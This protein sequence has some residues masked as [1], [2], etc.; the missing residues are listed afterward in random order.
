MING[1]LNSVVAT[2]KKGVPGV[3][4]HAL[5]AIQDENTRL[6]L[7]SIVDGWHVRNGATGS[8][9]G[10]FVTRAEIN[11][12]VTT[13]TRQAVSQ[14]GSLSLSPGEISRA[15]SDLHTQVFESQLFKVLESRIDLIDSPDG[16]IDQFNNLRDG[17]TDITILDEEGNKVT[18]IK[19][20]RESTDNNTAL[21]GQIN[22][23][24]STSTSAAAK[25]LFTVSST[26]YDEKTGLGVVNDRLDDKKTGLVAS[27]A[28]VTEEVETRVN[29]DNALATAINT[30]WATVGDTTALISRKDE[31]LANRTAAKATSWEQV[32][33]AIKDDAGNVIYSSTIK[34]TA[35][36]AANLAGELSAQYT[37]K[38]DVNGYISG[39]GLASTE[40]NGVP[41][42]DFIVRA[43]RFSIVSPTEENK[44]AVIMSNNTIVVYDEN[45]AARVRIGKLS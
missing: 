14:L 40:V 10:A 31:V 29:E 39:I 20:L 35:E 37:V 25:A 41:T 13:S 3:P 28:A 23:V 16:L 9:D 15:L 4:L 27:R 22:E 36:T 34:T 44:A 38:L 42:S 18:T 24:S 30:I 2:V 11:G 6:V 43:D 32:Q 12:V 19:G 45:G 7:Q 5:D 1:V 17:K 21:I 8:G 26:V 33:S